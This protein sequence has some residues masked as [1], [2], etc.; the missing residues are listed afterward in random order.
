MASN[1]V[2]LP[3]AHLNTVPHGSEEPTYLHSDDPIVMA[4]ECAEHPAA[5]NTITNDD[6]EFG[7]NDGNNYDEEDAE[8]GNINREK[9]SNRH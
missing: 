2:R 9:R 3:R 7:F 4:E 1:E 6:V 8:G 5:D